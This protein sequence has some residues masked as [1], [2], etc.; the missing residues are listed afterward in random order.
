[1]GHSPIY[2]YLQ[3]LRRRYKVKRREAPPSQPTCSS[4]A[5]RPV[6]C[7]GCIKV[8]FEICSQSE[9]KCAQ[10]CGHYRS[11]KASSGRTEIAFN[12]NVRSLVENYRQVLNDGK[13]VSLADAYTLYSRKPSRKRKCCDKTR[14]QKERSSI[15][16]KSTGFQK[17]SDG[18]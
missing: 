11:G 8:T 1:M 10:N 5:F 17:S 12:N 15:G 18:S 14:K 4:G 7:F 9:I 2:K 13:K 3:T 6:G 16:R